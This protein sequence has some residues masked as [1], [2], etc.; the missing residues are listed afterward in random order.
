MSVLEHY[1]EH[2]CARLLGGS[3]QDVR[4][5]RLGALEQLVYSHRTLSARHSVTDLQETHI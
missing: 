5:A 3:H 4:R 2:D 1:S